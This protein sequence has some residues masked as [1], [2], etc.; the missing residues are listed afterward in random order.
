MPWRQKNPGPQDA[1]PGKPGMESPH[2]PRPHQDQLEVRPQS[3]PMQIRL[4]KEFFQA[5]KDLV[6]R[7]NTQIHGLRS[8]TLMLGQIPPEV[9]TLPPCD[10][11]D[12]RRPF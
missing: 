9:R 6:R 3:R 5:V 8:S 4:Q 2:E 10:A 11:E 1:A 12:A 7:S